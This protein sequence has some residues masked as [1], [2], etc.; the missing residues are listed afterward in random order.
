MAG[1]RSDG[2]DGVYVPVL[3]EGRAGAVE[4][5]EDGRV[6][7]AL[8]VVPG[9]GATATDVALGTE[10]RAGSPLRTRPWP[11][12]FVIVLLCAEWIGRR[13]SGLR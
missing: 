13:R 1:L 9:A 10:D 8:A 12:L 3:V 7:A 2:R 5:V 4:E 6:L 11:Y